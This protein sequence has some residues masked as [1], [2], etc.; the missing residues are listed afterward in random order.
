M[1]YSEFALEDLQRD[2]GV[3]PRVSPLFAQSEPAVA[4]AWLLDHF[5]RAKQIPLLS[6]K[7]RGELLVM[8]VLMAF[9]EL[10][11]ECVSIYSGVRLDVVPEQGLAGECDFII[12]RT[13]PLPEVQ[14]PVITLVEAKR[15]E[16][17]LGFSQCAAQM[18]G[19]R[20]F[21]E[22][23]GHPGPIYGCITSGEAWQFLR[24][25]EDVL[26]LDPQRHYIDDP[27]AILGVLLRILQECAIA[28]DPAP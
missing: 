24:L 25:D 23:S 11:L 7:A 13:P 4:P 22:R 14:A 8:P 19:A 3:V 5:S 15:G 12:T 6:E 28:S 17:E 2:F 20:V 9:R 27:G 21:N 26:T 18:V 1:S 16:I 10:S